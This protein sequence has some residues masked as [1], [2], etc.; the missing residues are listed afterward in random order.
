MPKMLDITTSLFIL[1]LVV[2]GIDNI[3]LGWL[4]YMTSAS[5]ISRTLFLDEC[6]HSQDEV[7]SHDEVSPTKN[8][9]SE[10]LMILSTPPCPLV[11]SIVQP[12]KPHNH[13][14]KKTGHIFVTPLR[15]DFKNES[16]TSK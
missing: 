12:H 10:P 16:M 2:V 7:S 11:T 15:I 3:L 8:I 13:K 9:S 5:F 1:Y 4:L 14:K 6:I